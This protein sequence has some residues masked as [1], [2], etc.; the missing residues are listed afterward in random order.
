M[1]KIDNKQVYKQINVKLQ[2]LINV[3]EN[4][5]LGSNKMGESFFFRWIVKEYYFGKPKF[6]L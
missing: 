2:V 3:M 4:R 1:R 6:E 5:H